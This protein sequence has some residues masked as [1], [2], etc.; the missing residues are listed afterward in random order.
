VVRSQQD[1][2]RRNVFPEMHVRFGRYANNLGHID[3]PGC[4]RCHDDNYTSKDGK[5][6]GQECDSCHAIE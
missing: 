4:F 6:I 3:S 5:K 2:Y 1:G